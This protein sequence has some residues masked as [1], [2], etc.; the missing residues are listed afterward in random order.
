MRSLLLI[1]SREDP[2]SAKNVDALMNDF[3]SG[4][5]VPNHLQARFSNVGVSAQR[6]LYQRMVAVLY[7]YIELCP[8]IN[9]PLGGGATVSFTT[10]DVITAPKHSFE[11]AV[12]VPNQWIGRCSLV[13]T[14]L[15]NGAKFHNIFVRTTASNEAQIQINHT[16]SATASTFVIEGMYV[17]RT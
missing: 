9:N 14:Q 1:K 15:S 7:V 4:I 8:D 3:S 6:G 2:T 5:F 12:Y 10:G 16:I 17:T 13:M 11:P